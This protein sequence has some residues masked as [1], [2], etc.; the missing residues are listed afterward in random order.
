M[1]IKLSHYP[2]RKSNLINPF[3]VKSIYS[4]FN[5]VTEESN[6]KIEFVDGTFT[7]VY[8]TV[9]EIYSLQMN[10]SDYTQKT[11]DESINKKYRESRYEIPS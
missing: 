3:L 1:F 11:I 4:V 5:R 10:Q 2:T 7:N 6:T 8:E 9:D